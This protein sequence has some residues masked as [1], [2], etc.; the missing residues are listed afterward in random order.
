MDKLSKQENL[1]LIA[2]FDPN[3]RRKM[4]EGAVN[5]TRT[6]LCEVQDSLKN[7]VNTKEFKI[8]VESPK[9]FAGVYAQ[10]RVVLESFKKFLDKWHNNNKRRKAVRNKNQNKNKKKQAKVTNVAHK[11]KQIRNKR[12][13][14]VR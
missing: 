5:M 13:K 9:D 3:K 4:F 2:G 12:K 1:P 10:D 8:N 7:G 6:L 11:P 14:L